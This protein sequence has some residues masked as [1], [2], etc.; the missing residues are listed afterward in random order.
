MTREIKFRAWSTMVCK[1]EQ[2]S[3]ID[4]GGNEIRKGCPCAVV[5]DGDG[6]IPLE[7]TTLMQFTGL[8]DKGGIEMFEGDI[9]SYTLTYGSSDDEVQGLSIIKYEVHGF[10]PFTHQVSCEDE[11]YNMSID[12][13]IVIGNIHENPELLEE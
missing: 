11:Y 6:C 1:M 3:C 5:H 7:N 2:V 4:F 10:S 9:I 8:H 12:N 13:V